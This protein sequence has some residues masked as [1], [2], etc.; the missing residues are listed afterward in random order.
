MLKKIQFG[1]KIVLFGDFWTEFGKTIV[2]FEVIILK[3]FNIEN[4]M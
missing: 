4:F 1:I 2:I 3:F